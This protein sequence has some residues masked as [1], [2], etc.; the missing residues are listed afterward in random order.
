[1]KIRWADNSVI[2]LL[3]FYGFL[4]AFSFPN[5]SSAAASHGQPSPGRLLSLHFQNARIRS[6]LNEIEQQ[7]GFS[8][9]FSDALIDEE[10]SVNLVVDKKPLTDVLQALFENT[11]IDFKICAD[12]LVELTQKMP[13][14]LIGRVR[15]KETKLPL[16]GANIYLENTHLGTASNIRGHF[17]IEHIPAG[18][19][20]LHVTFIGFD[21]SKKSDVLIKSGE[22]TFVE[23]EL[24]NTVVT[25]DTIYSNGS[26]EIS[27]DEDRISISEAELRSQP[28]SAGD[29]SRSFN[30]QPGVTPQTD[31]ANSI[32]ITG[33]TPFGLVHRVDGM[34][35]PYPNHFPIARTGIGLVHVLSM[36]NIS[37]AELMTS[38]VPVTTGDV[39]SA[40]LDL[41]VR[42]GN[43]QKMV[44]KLDSDSF[45]FHASS[46]GPIFKGRGSFLFSVR[47]SYLD[48]IAKILKIPTIL[49]YKDNLVKIVYDIKTN[50]KL[51]L[52]MISSVDN[53]MQSEKDAKRN[54]LDSHF[55]G[56]IKNNLTGISL[57]NFD[58]HWFFKS[59]ITF[60]FL[61]YKGY[62]FDSA[63]ES[64]IFAGQAVEKTFSFRTD[65]YF[66]INKKRA[67]ETGL[68]FKLTRISDKYRFSE[69][70]DHF[71]NKIDSASVRTNQ[72]DF[73][74]GSY[75]NYHWQ[76]SDK[77]NVQI[78]LR[79]DY[80]SHN[81]R[82]HLAPRI[83]LFSKWSETTAF[84]F[85]SG[86]YYQSLPTALL[87]QKESNRNLNNLFS[88]QHSLKWTQLLH[89]NLKMSLELFSKH[90]KNFPLSEQHPQLFILD[91]IAQKNQL[92]FS[93]FNS[94]SDIGEALA[95]GVDVSVQTS[96]SR[97]ICGMASISYLV[98][99]YKDYHR[100]WQNRAFD[101]RVKLGFEGGFKL[102]KKWEIVARWIYMSGRPYAPL[103]ITTS[104]KLNTTV[105]DQTRFNQVRLPAYHSLNIRISRHFKFKKS[106]LSVYLSIWN[107]YNRKNI[108]NYQWSRARGRQRTN[109]QLPVVPFIGFKYVI[110]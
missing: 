74:F 52:L 4:A 40:Q 66:Q 84:R 53:T 15:D 46:Q 38:G 54:D 65:F 13:G 61:K 7:S 97:Q 29:V 19:Y 37:R 24:K 2:F 47:R 41:Y 96:R 20:E 49:I 30:A 51:N 11:Q 16:S 98:S 18:R 109:R 79:G 104:N 105:F 78:G 31:L 71:G 60:S 23:V 89:E 76:P 32:S 28:G 57:I 26:K 77:F 102:S 63:L 92:H 67:L 55:K 80:Y 68:E 10:N 100:E 95:R 8:F 35:F 34:E 44:E 62:K 42:E 3:S 82:F 101:S 33:T 6:V 64:E 73:R 86:L 81:R 59:H 50:L 39:L 1:M 9:S 25:L 87:Y 88:I 56:D 70:I 90:N 27:I 107:L 43:R 17:Y 103:D 99:K 14:T 94:L 22:K 110:E 91:E 45:G 12:S 48:L 106:H 72:R 21:A 58:E 75:V 85:T 93:Y 108:L 5:R 83:A 36:E 69:Y